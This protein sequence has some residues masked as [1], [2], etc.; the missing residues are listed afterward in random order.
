MAYLSHGHNRGQLVL[1]TAFLLAV[2]F[3]A[4]ALVV[5]SAIFT[6]NMATRDDV[7]GSHEVLDFRSEVEA[8]AGALLT[9]VN[10]NSTLGESDLKDGISAFSL[11]GSNQQSMQGRLVD[12]T[13]D[14]IEEDGT[15]IAQDNSSRN[16]TSTG[17][18][19][20]WN[21]TD[22]TVQ[23]VR[24][25]EIN[26]TD[27]DADGFDD[28]TLVVNDTDTADR[29]EMTVSEAS[30]DIVVEV[31]H[32][33]HFTTQTCTREHDSSTTIDVTGATVG[34]EPCLALGQLQDSA[35]TNLS[36]A[37]GVDDYRIRFE[38]GNEIEGTYSL[39][40]GNSGTH[41]SSNLDNGPGSGLPYYDTDAIYSIVL[42]YEFYTSDV[43]YETDIRVA[44]GEVS[45]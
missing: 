29:W 23:K 18:A 30:G 14:S 5:N 15:R 28:F 12:V 16:F 4:L 1:V 3:V 33:D 36:F 17:G 2:T 26:V 43:G 11:E 10:E 27:P 25:F 38:D 7:A 24:N 39:V 19:D 41:K 20:D 32:P 45:S 37:E 21:L 31:D 42:S 22:D 35:G 8:N 6:E 40:F 9:H 44:P 34:G 13:Y